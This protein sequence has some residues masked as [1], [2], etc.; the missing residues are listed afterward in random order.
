LVTGLRKTNLYLSFLSFWKIPL[1]FYCRPKVIFI[2][3]T[4]IKVRIKLRRRV[5]NHLGSMYLGAL[6]IGADITAGY[7]AFHFLQMHKKKISLIFKDFHADFHKRSTG[8][9]E[10]TCTMG[11]EIKDMIEESIATSNR[12][13][14]PVTVNAS[15]PSI[16]DEVVAKF[17]LTLS[18]KVK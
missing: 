12:V 7:F 1:L 16:S 5:K 3:D 4:T 11:P 8:D 10:F 14:L 13:N 17:I 15:V 2:D 6:T 9:V 18:V